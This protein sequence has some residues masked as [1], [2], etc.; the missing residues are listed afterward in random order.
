MTATLHD[1]ARS[2]PVLWSPNLSLGVNLLAD[3]VGR[4]G[5]VLPGS[6]P[7]HVDDIHHQWKKDAP[8]GTALML[9]GRVADERVGDDSAITYSSTREGEVIGV[10]TVRFTLEGEEFELVHRAQARSIYALGALAAGRWLATCEAGYYTAA[11][12]LQSI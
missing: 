3:L 1:A 2:V 4:A 6:V 11:D 12:W 9:G 7:V 10:H 8:S 5:A